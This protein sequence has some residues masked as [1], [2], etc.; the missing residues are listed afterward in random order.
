MGWPEALGAQMDY[1][2]TWNDGTCKLYE[3]VEPQDHDID[4]ASVFESNGDLYVIPMYSFREM[5]VV[6]D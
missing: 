1:L 5:R 2:F 6:R 3:N 4:N